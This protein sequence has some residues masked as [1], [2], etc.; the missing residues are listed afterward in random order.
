M[1]RKSMSARENVRQCF[2]GFVSRDKTL[3]C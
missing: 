1:V 2:I 3:L